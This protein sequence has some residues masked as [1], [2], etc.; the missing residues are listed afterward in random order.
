MA[1]EINGA[2]QAVLAQHAGAR[3]ILRLPGAVAVV[4]DEKRIVLRIL[5]RER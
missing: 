2:V 4:L 3:R 1:V 5:Q